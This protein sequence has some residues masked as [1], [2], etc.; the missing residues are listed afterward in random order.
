ME[1]G[2]SQKRGRTESKGVK[3][4]QEQGMVKQVGARP[5]MLG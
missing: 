1:V 2:E 3:I 4:R 5:V